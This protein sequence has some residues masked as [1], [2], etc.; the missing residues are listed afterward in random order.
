MRAYLFVCMLA[1]RLQT[2]LRWRLLE[3]GVEEDKVAEEQERL[4]EDLG[5]VERVRV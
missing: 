3:S 4:L 5:R 1:L 2:A